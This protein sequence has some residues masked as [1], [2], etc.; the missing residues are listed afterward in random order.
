ML[1]LC[2]GF[3]GW[4]CPFWGCSA[5]RCGSCVLLVVG[6]P[7]YVLQHGCA[8]CSYVCSICCVVCSVLSIFFLRDRCSFIIFRLLSTVAVRVRR[9]RGGEDLGVDHS[10]LLVSPCG[11][12]LVE[13]ILEL[14][15]AREHSRLVL[16]VTR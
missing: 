13:C 12:E 1:F 5:S 8:V 4:G 10:G 9:L 16:T 2:L 15:R 14:V 6:R 7:I 3:P 11:P